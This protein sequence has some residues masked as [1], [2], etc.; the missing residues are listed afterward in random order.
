MVC[1]HVYTNITPPPNYRACYGPV[2]G[3]L[4]AQLKLDELRFW[5]KCWGDAC[6]ALKTKAQLVKM[7]E[8][9]IVCNDTPP[10]TC[11]GIKTA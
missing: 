6:K 2:S 1:E 3:R 9:H 8:I 10:M 5:L 11:F 4:P 7:F